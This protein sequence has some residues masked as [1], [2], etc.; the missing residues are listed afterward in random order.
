MSWLD[1]NNLAGLGQPGWQSEAT[2]MPNAYALSKMTE[3]QLL[4]L[5][6]ELVK[7][8]GS[9]FDPDVLRVRELIEKKREALGVART[10]IVE[11]VRRYPA[12]PFVVEPV[13][14]WAKAGM[15]LGGLAVLAAVVVVATSGPRRRRDSWA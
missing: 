13:P 5:K 14:T 3:Q 4:D 1:P 11:V 9:I 10:P 8:R 15:F 6:Y 2:L 12:A 7:A